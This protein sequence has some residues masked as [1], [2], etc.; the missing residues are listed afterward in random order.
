MP[1]PSGCR[2][3]NLNQ[4]TFS[5]VD[6]LSFLPK[7]KHQDTDQATRIRTW[8]KKAYCIKYPTYVATFVDTPRLLPA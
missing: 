5:S 4:S 1:Q 8:S 7:H 6:T 2:R 3:K